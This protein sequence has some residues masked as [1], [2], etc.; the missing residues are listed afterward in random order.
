LPIADLLKVENQR[1]NIKD[2]RPKIKD[3]NRNGQRTTDKQIGNWQSAITR[4][5]LC[6]QYGARQS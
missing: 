4:S 1:S 2:Q 5:V 6:S 3:Q